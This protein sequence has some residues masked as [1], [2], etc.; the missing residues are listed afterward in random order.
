LPSRRPSQKGWLSRVGL[1]SG[2]SGVTT[3]ALM[4]PSA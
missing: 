3:A 4:P 2:R 1:G